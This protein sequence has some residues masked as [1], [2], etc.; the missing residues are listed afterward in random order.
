[1]IKIPFAYSLDHKRVVEVGSVKP[2]RACRCVCPSCG[3]AVQAKRG[4]VNVWHFAHDPAP[5]SL[6]TTECDISFLVCCRQFIA[7]AAL[8]G[9]ISELTTPPYIRFDE[10]ITKG[11]RLVDLIWEPGPNNFDLTTRVGNRN[12]HLYLSYPKREKP[13]I[14]SE[15]NEDGYLEIP[16]QVIEQS[17]EQHAR[18]GRNI[19]RQAQELFIHQNDHRWLFHPKATSKR[20]AMAK[21]RYE[22]V[23]GKEEYREQ[24][25]SH[26]KTTLPPPRP[27]WASRPGSAAKPET[28]QDAS[29]NPLTGNVTHYPKGYKGL[30]AKEKAVINASPE[31]FDRLYQE[32]KANGATKHQAKIKA[33]YNLILAE[34]RKKRLQRDL[35]DAPG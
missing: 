13:V 26:A 28:P 16:I 29:A 25:L 12:L 23:R 14:P 11:N 22:A 2:G 20:V 33:I 6:P 32:Y 8:A 9:D 1:M 21:S 3:Q 19:L 15:A 31:Q 27:L 17:I 5:G 24:E 4:E 35:W 34:Q 7:D 18:D 10:Q 30:T